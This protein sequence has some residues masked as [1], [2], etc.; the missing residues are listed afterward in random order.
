[1]TT[2]HVGPKRAP[3]RNFYLVKQPAGQV[4]VAAGNV[5]GVDQNGNDMVPTPPPPPTIVD[6][7]SVSHESNRA[8]QEAENKALVDVK[9]VAALEREKDSLKA[10]IKKL[11]AN[12]TTASKSLTKLK[13]TNTQLTKDKHDLEKSNKSLKK[14][15]ESLRGELDSDEIEFPDKLAVIAV[16][17]LRQI[18]KGLT[19]AVTLQSDELEENV[20]ALMLLN[21]DVL[22][23]VVDK[24]QPAAPPKKSPPKKKA[25]PARKKKGR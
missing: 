14:L 19:M 1:M 15:V 20:N 2:K 9:L 7:A 22:E 25:G 10:E 8:V 23:K 24:V 11:K 18:S 21:T 6:G 3:R 12:R 13:N 4:P 5:S 17:N 16:K